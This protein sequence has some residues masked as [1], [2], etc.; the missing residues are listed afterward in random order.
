MTENSLKFYKIKILKFKILNFYF[1][2][3]LRKKNFLVLHLFI[4]INLMSKL[5]DFLFAIEKHGIVQKFNV[6]FYQNLY[7]QEEIAKRV[8]FFVK[9]KIISNI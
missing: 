2:K 6:V 9:N 3:N 5:F 8:Q 1:K 7:Q 4:L